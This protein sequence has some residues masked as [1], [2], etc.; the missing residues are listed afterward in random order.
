MDGPNG[1]FAFVMQ[2]TNF[3]LPAITA[4]LFDV[5]IYFVRLCRRLS[6]SQNKLPRTQNTNSITIGGDRY[7][8]VDDILAVTVPMFVCNVICTMSQLAGACKSAV[9]LHVLSA[10]VDAANI[11][12]YLRFMSAFR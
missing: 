2:A 11:G 4:I 3:I 1:Y 6:D 8:S 9:L 10:G 5:C 7:W 12:I